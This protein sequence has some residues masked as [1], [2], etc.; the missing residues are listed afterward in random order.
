[1]QSAGDD[2]VVL[3]GVGYT[4]NPKVLS[5]RFIQAFFQAAKR[6]PQKFL[7]KLEGHL[8]NVPSNVKIMSWI[9]QQDVLAHNAT[10]LF[11]NHCG[12]QGVTEALYH[13]VP[14]VG[15]PIFLD[16]G[17]YLVKLVKH[18]VAIPLDRQTAT[19]EV[20]YQTLR[21]AL[22]NP[23]FKHNAKRLSKLMKDTPDKLTPQERALQLVEY[24]VRQKG[25][26]HLKM[27][28]RHL[29]FFQYFCIDIFVFVFTLLFTSYKLGKIVWRKVSS[30]KIQIQI[31][32]RKESSLFRKRVGGKIEKVL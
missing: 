25:A 15:L 24:L 1:M 8:E 7:M 6:L 29:N 5:K 10:R 27:H 19:A 23:S 9:P 32:T 18:G 13:A 28:S 31:Q 12:L 11:V 2:G 4:I 16:Q 22:N 3:F 21:R 17:D 14:M 20:I 26:N 30:S